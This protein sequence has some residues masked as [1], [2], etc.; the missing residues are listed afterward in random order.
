MVDIIIRK[1]ENLEV[2]DEI[3]GNGSQFFVVL[4]FA[5]MKMFELAPL[6]RG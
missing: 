4:L 5:L 6:Q 1:L 3:K 2:M